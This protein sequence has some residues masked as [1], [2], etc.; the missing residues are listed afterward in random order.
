[1]Y[2][3][4]LKSES[5][6]ET[7]EANYAPF[8][9]C[10]MVSVQFA[11][12]A[13]L[14]SHMERH[15]C[16]T[17]IL[18]HAEILKF[19]ASSLIGKC[20]FGDLVSWRSS[21]LP[22]LCFGVMNLLSMWCTRKGVE[23]SVFVVLMQLKLVFTALF[24]RAVLKRSFSVIKTLALLSVCLGC[25]GATSVETQPSVE[26]HKMAIL[27]L[28]VE[29]CISGFSSVFIQKLFNNN[30]ERMWSRNIQLAA[31]STVM[32]ASLGIYEDCSLVSMS[33][34][35][36][37]LA[38]VSAG[39]GVLVALSLVFAGAVEKTVATSAAIVFTIAAEWI[40]TSHSPPLTKLSSSMCVLT[41]AAIYALSK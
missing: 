24:S 9:V 5:T 25:I 36:V 37:V 1:M 34:Q 13:I 35:D 38:V 39:G 15:A 2:T 41:S 26:T 30:L 22:T 27:G 6:V 29:T 40:I 33:V 11:T 17:T 14:R 3:P 20:V 19:V 31:L 12:F 7:R 21:L 16:D 8:L 4:L 28:V 10:F 23:A 18:M 32:Y